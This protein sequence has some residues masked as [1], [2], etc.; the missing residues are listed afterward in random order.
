MSRLHGLSKCKAQFQFFN[1]GGRGGLCVG[2]ESW[3]GLVCSTADRHG[4]ILISS[5]LFQVLFG[6]LYLVVRLTMPIH[7][8]MQNAECSMDCI[9]SDF[10]DDDT[11]MPMIP[12]T[13]FVVFAF[14]PGCRCFNSAGFHLISRIG[15]K[16]K[17]KRTRRDCSEVLAP[18]F[19]LVGAALL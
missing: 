5:V 14:C 18:G 3:C 6:V 1:N 16:W 11:D 17:P 12:I 19:D 9:P 13:S 4:L 7:A 15:P 10:D 2:A 8:R